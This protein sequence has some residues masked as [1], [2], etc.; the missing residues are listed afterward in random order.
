MKKILLT[1]IMSLFLLTIQAQQT[2][3]FRYVRTNAKGLYETIFTIFDINSTQQQKDLISDLKKL[4]SVVDCKI[5]YNKRCKI[6]SKEQLNLP[7]TRAVLNKHNTDL[8]INYC[9]ISDES[10]KTELLKEKKYTRK[11]CR[12]QYLQAIGNSPQ[13]SPKNQTT[14]H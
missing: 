11:Q 5:F 9:I 7:D 2:N 13:I 8:D 14:K 6:T 4:K 10:L 12:Y 1:S 3:K